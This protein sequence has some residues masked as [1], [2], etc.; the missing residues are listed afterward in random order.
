MKT[1]FIG[2][3]RSGKSSNAEKFILSKR[4]IKP[5]YL[6]T[7]EFF[8]DEM[9]EKVLH[10]QK[11]RGDEF[12]TLEEPLLLYDIIKTQTKPV[13]VECISMWINNMLYH[14]KVTNR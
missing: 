4:D 10:H 2:G 9:K 6:A 14:K 11:L 3:I 8:D 12:I 7:N 13:L 1:L 5:I